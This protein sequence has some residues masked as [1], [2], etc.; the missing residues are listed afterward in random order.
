MCHLLPL[1]FKTLNVVPELVTVLGSNLLFSLIFNLNCT[2][3]YKNPKIPLLPQL[4][5]HPKP[6]EKMVFWGFI[7]NAQF[8][9]NMGRDNKLLTNIIRSLETKLKFLKLKGSKLH[10]PYS[11]WC[12]TVINPYVYLSKFLCSS[13]FSW[14]WY[15]GKHIHIMLMT[16]LSPVL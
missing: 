1:N 15:Y 16:T 13:W 14:S 3:F 5:I 4:N 2:F 7:T 10:Y 12:L 8:N 11:T 9:L 6:R